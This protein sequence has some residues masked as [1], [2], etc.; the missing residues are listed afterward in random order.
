ME[1]AFE[2]ANVWREADFHNF[3]FSMKASNPLVMV[4]AYRLLAEEMSHN[5][6][7]DP[8]HLGV[9]E[10]SCAGVAART[11]LGKLVVRGRDVAWVRT[12]NSVHQVP[13][14][15]LTDLRDGR[16]MSCTWGVHRGGL[17]W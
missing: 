12:N 2:F 15:L 4:Q 10:V 9:T 1:S 6:W 14:C 16:A 11:S 8:M 13:L 7:D 5:G 17:W 3:L